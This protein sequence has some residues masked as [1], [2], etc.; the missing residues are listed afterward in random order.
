MDGARTTRY[1]G[2]NWYAVVMGTA[3]VATGAEAVPARV[4]GLRALGT[5]AWALS[6]LLLAALLAA[7]AGHFR[8]HRDVAAAHL[9]DPA[10]AVFYGCPPMALLAVGNATLAAGSRVVGE[11]AAVAADAVLWT[12]GT[13]TAAAVAAAIPCLLITR[14]AHR[15]AAPNP[16]WLLPVVAPMVAAAA[17]PPLAAHLPPGQP[18]ATLLCACLAL[19]GASLLATLVVLPGVWSGLVRGCLGAPVSPL[20]PTLFLVLGPLGQS[21]TAVGQ[22]ADAAHAHAAE[23][24]VFSV[25]YGVPVMGFALLWLAVAA[26]ANARALRAGMP[27]AMT[28][29]AYT[30]P[31][32]TCVTGAAVLA[33]HTGL[34]VFSYLSAAL[35]LLLLLAWAVAGARTLRGVLDGRLLR[36][37]PN[38]PHAPG[39]GTV[40]IGASMGTMPGVPR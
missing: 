22:I 27:F 5:A 31:V 4:P 21:T 10:T 15:D 25:L 1:I 29:W 6:A 24:K 17:G 9:A 26:A 30:F 28:W 19:F 33:R 20:V 13:V 40:A 14:H 16:T 34:A 39:N 32:G 2:P 36:P 37:A 8:R 7:R 35:Y 38:R 18:R 3:I 11:R 23:L 12:A